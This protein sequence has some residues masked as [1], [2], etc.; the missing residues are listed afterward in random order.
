MNNGSYSR[1][2]HKMKESRRNNFIFLLFLPLL[3]GCAK[4]KDQSS[5]IAAG[6]LYKKSLSLLEAYT[7]SLKNA[8]DS[9]HVES[10][11]RAFDSKI[12]AINFEFPP[13]TDLRM[14]EEE[15][16]SL[17]K[18]ADRMVST[19]KKRL[20]SFAAISQDT[21]PSDSVATKL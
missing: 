9:A 17:I 10:L 21:I 19:R 6:Q 2:S 8:R 3:C 7:D 15:N 4:E 20:A 16:D 1:L 14:T 13:D 18:M 11:D 5:H 12:N